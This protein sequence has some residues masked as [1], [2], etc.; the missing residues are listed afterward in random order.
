MKPE[1]VQKLA[2]AIEKYMDAT[3]AESH[4]AEE[5]P[6]TVEADDAET[7]EGNP[8]PGNVRVY[9]LA[10]EA[11]MKSTELADK[12]IELGYDIKGY[13]STVDGETAAKIRNEVLKGETA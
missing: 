5:T 1:R 11:G 12:L 10:K 7:A 9:E 6:A 13:N 3:A 8:E 4:L 2:A